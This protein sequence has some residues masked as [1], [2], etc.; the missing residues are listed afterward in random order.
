MTFRAERLD[1]VALVVDDMERSTLWYGRALAMER[2][3]ADV[4]TGSGDPVVLCN[5]EACV[6]LFAPADGDAVGDGRSRH[7]V[8]KL[9][10]PNFV[11]AQLH[12]DAAGIPYELWDHRI[13]HSLYVRDPDGHQ[14][15]LTT[16]ELEAVDVNRERRGSDRKV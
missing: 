10:R 3:F 11:E 1:H 13:S 4:W 9:D 5:D 15:E 2:R 16:Y 12:L 6:A 14:V 7:F 8:L